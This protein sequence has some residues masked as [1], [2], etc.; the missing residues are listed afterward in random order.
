[1]TKIRTVRVTLEIDLASLPRDEWQD[2]LEDLYDGDGDSDLDEASDDWP[3]EELSTDEVAS[4]VEQGTYH[5]EIFAGTMLY[6]RVAE[7]R[8]ISHEFVEDKSSPQGG[9]PSHD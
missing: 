6:L 9:A 1:M 3:L 4:C 8:V 2:E 7:T 5:P